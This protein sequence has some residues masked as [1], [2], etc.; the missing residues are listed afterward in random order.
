MEPQ[1]KITKPFRGQRGSKRLD[2]TDMRSLMRDQKLWCSVGRVFLPPGQA[3]H[4]AIEDGDIHIEVVL[5]PSLGDVTCRL[6]AGMW[7]VPAI[8]EEVVVVL[9]EGE[10]SFMPTIIG[11]LSTGVVPSAQQPSPTRIVIQRDEVAIHDGTG[12]ANPLPTLASLQAS[13]DKLNEL[14]GK[15][16]LHVHNGGTLGGGLTGPPQAP[17]VAITN[18]DDA[19]GTTVLKGK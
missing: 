8:G 9:P 10:L 15:Y 5:Q 16:K 13:I 18:A 3:Q 11:I 4:Y 12:G 1:V 2:L 17:N 6:A 14:V 19:V 7:L